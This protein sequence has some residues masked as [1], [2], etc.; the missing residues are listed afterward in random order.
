MS[1][2]QHIQQLVPA[3]QPLATNLLEQAAAKGYKLRITHSYRSPEEQAQ[4]YAQGRGA[5]TY[6]GTTYVATSTKIVTNAKPGDSLHNTR[7]AF[8]L[9]DTERGYNINWEEI[10]VIGESLG[11]I[12][13][14]RWKMVD[15]THFEYTGPETVPQVLASAPVTETP[16]PD[17]YR[18]FTRDELF[19]TLYSYQVRIFKQ[20]WPT[21]E[22]KRH[23][24]DLWREKY[25]EAAPEDCVTEI[26]AEQY[27][28]ELAGLSI[29]F[30]PITATLYRKVN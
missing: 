6:N 22:D 7:R 4:L 8:D 24:V 19:E 17:I 1:N 5:F 29:Q 15:S 28:N 12:A 27:K 23:A 20:D 9:V 16:M 14:H 26:V 18:S 11:L 21:T 30:E 2:E 25:N 13:G 3:L 10:A